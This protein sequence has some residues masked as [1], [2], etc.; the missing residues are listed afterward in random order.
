MKLSS[1]KVGNFDL[2]DST[3][4]TEPTVK[5]HPTLQTGGTSFIVASRTLARALTFEHFL[6][7]GIAVHVFNDLDDPL[8]KTYEAMKKVR[9]V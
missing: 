8:W 9:Y 5:C 7:L 6:K 1:G 4:L 2:G 3:F